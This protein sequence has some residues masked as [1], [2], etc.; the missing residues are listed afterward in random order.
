MRLFYKGLVLFGTDFSSIAN[1][2]KHKTRNQVINKYHWEEKKCR[3][4]I[5]EALNSH[6]KCES[7]LIEN[8]NDIIPLESEIRRIRKNSMFSADSMD[9]TIKKNIR[10]NLNIF[11]KLK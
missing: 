9:I 5:E 2:L 4:W 7:K 10:R 6:T 11:W 3:E 1:S 8:F